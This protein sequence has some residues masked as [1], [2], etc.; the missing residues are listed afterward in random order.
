[1]VSWMVA[2]KNLIP[3][4]CGKLW[5]QLGTSH[6]STMGLTINYRCPNTLTKKTLVKVSS[7]GLK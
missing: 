7:F 6:F 3:K 2:L 4:L 1:M 5:D